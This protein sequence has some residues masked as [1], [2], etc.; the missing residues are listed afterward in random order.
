MGKFEKVVVLAVLFLVT[1]IL[2]VSL[3]TDPEQEITYAALG[4]GAES[5]PE[6]LSSL[7]MAPEMDG[8]MEV[9]AGPDAWEWT[10]QDADETAGAGFDPGSALLSGQIEGLAEELLLPAVQ[11]PEG[12]ILI[13][14]RG[15]KESFDPA[16]FLHTV[17][18]GE[19]YETLALRYFGDAALTEM[20]QRANDDLRSAPISETVMI[21]AFNQSLR[22]A[23]RLSGMTYTVQ[24]GDQLSGI[25]LKV[26]GDARIWNRIYE[27]N[28]DIL[29][30]PDELRPGMVLRIP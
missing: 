8:A 26:Y 4:G 12:S 7:A 19:T 6:G 9:T 20:L 25:S 24:T 22:M 3:N 18:E 28:R 5:D 17:A 11:I 10:L 14:T 1:L 15:L 23:D 29:K 21:P 13:E 2:V 27:V 16:L 30:S